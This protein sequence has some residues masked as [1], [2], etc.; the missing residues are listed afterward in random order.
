MSASSMTASSEVQ[1]LPSAPEGS[2]AALDRRGLTAFVLLACGLAWLL[3]LGLVLSGHD[4]KSAAGFVVATMSMLMPSVAT[5]IVTRWVSPLRPLARRTGLGLGVRWKRFWAL[6][7]LG[8]PVVVLAALGLSVLL[9]RYPLD[10]GLSG[11]LAKLPHTEKLAPVI[12]KMTAHPH[13]FI[14]LA[15]AQATVIAPLLNA[16]FVLGEEWGWRGYLLPRLLPLGQ[17]RA[18]VLSGAIWGVWHAPLI[19]LGHNYP[20]HPVAGVFFMIVFCVLTGVLIGWTRLATGSVWPAVIIHGSINGLGP[21]A[22]ILNRAGTTVDMAE[23]GLLGWPGW[24]LMAALIGVLVLT[25]RLPVR[26]VPDGMSR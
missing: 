21:L 4:M 7:W 17:W 23:A 16:P 25:R 8:T 2:G 12:E 6:A 22:G 9:G 5:F 1:H 18:L 13:R 20:Q 14:A 3:A 10:L 15:V 11:L 24:L 19:L 26:D